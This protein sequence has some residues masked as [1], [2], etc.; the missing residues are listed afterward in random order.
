MNK[1]ELTPITEYQLKQC[2]L[3]SKYSVYSSLDEYEKRMQFNK[4]KIIEDIKNGKIAEF[5]VYNYLTNAFKNPTTPDLNIY[6]KYNKSYDA[7]I[8]LSNAN[9]HVKSHKVNIHYP[10]SWLFQKKDPLVT[11]KDDKD[12]LALVVLKEK[13]PSYMYLLK[14]QN[15]EFKKPVKEALRETKVCIYEYDLKIL[16]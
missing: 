1:I 3:F 5:M 10:P 14:I 13:F 2:E 4:N 7:D 15:V 16:V 11:N 12:F 8:I 6:D 9:I